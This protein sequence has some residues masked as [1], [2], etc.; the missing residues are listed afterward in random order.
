MSALVTKYSIKYRNNNFAY[1]IADI[2]IICLHFPEKPVRSN[3][4]C[5]IF[6][7]KNENS[8]PFILLRDCSNFLPG[9]QDNY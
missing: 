8:T 5:Y 4:Q 6:K 9:K 3:L 2:K 7:R 1:N